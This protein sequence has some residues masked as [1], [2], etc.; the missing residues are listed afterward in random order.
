MCAL[1]LTLLLSLVLQ[2]FGQTVPFAIHVEPVKIPGLPGL[3][4]FVY[5]QTADEWIL[6]GG[7]LDG[8]HARQP[9]NAFPATS[10]NTDIF[11][12]NP[13]TRQVWSASVNDLPIGLRDQLQGTNLNFHQESDTL[14][15]IGGYGFSQ[16]ANAHVTYPNLTTFCVS[17]LHDA[18]VSGQSIS[19]LFQQVTDTI[20]QVTGGQLGKIDDDFYLVGGHNF[21]GRYNPMNNPTFTQSYTE[22]IRKFRVAHQG[23]VPVV[24]NVSIITDATHLHRRDYNLVPQIYPDG[25]YGY[26][27]S[28]GVFQQQAD[29]PFLYPV[30]I[31]AQGHR[32]VTGFNQYLSNYH[33]AKAALYDAYNNEMHSLFFGGMSQCYYDG[34][35]L[36]QDNLVPFVRTISG[37]TRS[38]DSTYSE[39]VFPIEMPGFKGASSEFL[40]NKALPFSA[41]DIVNQNALFGDTILLGY[42]V[43]GITSPER[44]PFSSNRTH[45]TGADDSVYAVYLI[46]ANPGLGVKTL[47]GTNPYSIRVF[48]NPA[49]DT[50]F[51]ET[52]VFRDKPIWYFLNDNQ[53]KQVDTG[54]I[55][56]GDTGLFHVE[57]EFPKGLPAGAYHLTM[58]FEDRYYRTA[59]VIRS[60]K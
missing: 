60:D 14:Y 25:S 40:I 10:N 5:G 44:N 56:P 3:H 18:I 50:F 9:F 51:V 11:V 4:S 22:Q 45:L 48:P 59:T 17:C 24:S 42:V 35:Q 1:F 31:T 29:L 13:S 41:P 12:V 30:E 7:R 34:N 36:I 47:E 54:R 28:S 38:A 27:I 16:A 52:N 49:K 46:N 21:M 37:V 33:G 15:I 58:V 43:G 19:G 53:G 6:I 57:F 39:F 26:M 8:L 23:A 2:G 20:F 55:L 32:P